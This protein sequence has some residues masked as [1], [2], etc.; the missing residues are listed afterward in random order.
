MSL[1]WHTMIAVGVALAMVLMV[2]ITL[3]DAT[4]IFKIF[5]VILT[6]LA[7]SGSIY[8]ILRYNKLV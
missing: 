8:S 6:Y 1:I 2:T 3:S 4:P 5:G 7:A